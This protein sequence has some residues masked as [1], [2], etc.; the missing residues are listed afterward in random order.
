MRITIIRSDESYDASSSKQ[1]GAVTS[2]SPHT[3]PMSDSSIPAWTSLQGSS[4][5]TLCSLSS[6]YPECCNIFVIFELPATT[7]SGALWH[8]ATNEQA[9]VSLKFSW[10]TF[11]VR[12]CRRRLPEFSQNARKSD[13]YSNNYPLWTRHGDAGISMPENKMCKEPKMRWKSELK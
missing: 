11:S 6:S 1:T 12:E 4:S 9:N 8:A 10:S 3:C 5:A 2:L 7:P 13:E